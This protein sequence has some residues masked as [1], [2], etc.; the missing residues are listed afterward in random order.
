[1]AI[2]HWSETID[3]VKGFF[4]GVPQ[5]PFAEMAAVL[6]ERSNI[7]CSG[8]ENQQGIRRQVSWNAARFPAFWQI[9]LT[10]SW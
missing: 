1:M 2:K 10:G 4:E 7:H 8:L 6:A 9:Q 3:P 5:R